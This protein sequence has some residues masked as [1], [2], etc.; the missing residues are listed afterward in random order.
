MNDTKYLITDSV[1]IVFLVRN[2]GTYQMKI[3]ISYDLIYSWTIQLKI[4]I[5]KTYF[6]TVHFAEKYRSMYYLDIFLNGKSKVWKDSW[7]MY[8]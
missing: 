7:S 6:H 5:F 4:W 2:V 8:R 1:H 3:N